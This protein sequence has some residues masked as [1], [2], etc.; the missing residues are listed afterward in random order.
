MSNI[1]RH[2][3]GNVHKM[4]LQALTS[5]VSGRIESI[6]L[7]GLLRLRQACVSPKLLPNSIYK[8]INTLISS[9][10]QTA[11]DYIEMFCLKEEKVLV[12][13]QFVGALEEMEHILAERKIRY[14]KIYGDTRDRV[15]PIGR[16]QK[17]KTS[18]Y[19]NQLKGRWCRL[20]PYS[21]QQCHSLG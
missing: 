3:Y 12:F 7:E 14:E 11:L 10:L 17:I 16:F 20:E 8:G 13:S 1:E 18:P 4:V 19:F 15:S 2:L 6:A 5:G 9:K 21:S